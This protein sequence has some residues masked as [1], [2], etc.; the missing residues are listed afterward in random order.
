[1]LSLG[2]GICTDMEKKCTRCRTVKPLSD[3]YKTYGYA[4]GHYTWCKK[5]QS[6][7]SRIWGKNNPDKRKAASDRWRFSNPDRA[8]EVRRESA[9]RNRRPLTT[10]QRVRA[11]FAKY[12]RRELNGNKARR[13]TFSVL[14]Y[15]F[16]ELSAH[17]QRLFKPGMSWGNY[18]E[19]E[20][21]H[22]RHISSFKIAS[23]ED[24]KLKECWALSNLQ[25]LWKSD[26]RRKGKSY[27]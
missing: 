22:V 13:P 17:L 19:W 14:G 12:I 20:I 18:G 11:N 9:R 23:V 6:D 16:V 7:V 3:Y 8:R 27:A 24:P 25:P 2:L 26:N 21:D 1:M 5:C 15:G 4:D 10:A